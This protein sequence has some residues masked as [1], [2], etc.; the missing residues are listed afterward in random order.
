MT[1]NKTVESLTMAE[2]EQLIPDFQPKL[3]PG[4]LIAHYELFSKI[5]N[6][7]GAIVKCG[8]TEAEAFT[9]FAMFRKLMGNSK[10]QEMIAFQKSE[11]IFESIKLEEVMQLAVKNGRC[12]SLQKAQ[13]RLVEKGLNENIN[14]RTGPL[15]ESIPHFIEEHPEVKIALLNIDLEDFD[16]TNTALEFFYPRI[17]AGGLLIIDNYTSSPAEAEAVDQFLYHHKGI[18]LQQFPLVNGPFYLFKP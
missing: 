1:S 2:L 6:I 14:Y 10:H 5:K 17:V 11:S 3:K 18:V 15:N 12:N 13:Q 8:I 7:N 16:S 4:S 9:R